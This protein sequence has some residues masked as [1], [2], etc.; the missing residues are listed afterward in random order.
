MA[1]LL[2]YWQTMHPSLWLTLWLAG[3]VAVPGVLAQSGDAGAGDGQ[4]LPSG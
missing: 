1:K 3:T 2:L 4:N